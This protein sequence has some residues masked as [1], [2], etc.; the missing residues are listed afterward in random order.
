MGIPLFWTEPRVNNFRAVL[1]CFLFFSPL[2]MWGQRDLLNETISLQV[3]QQR[4][5]ETLSR[6]AEA[7]HF[8]FSYNANL[9]PG[10]SLVSLKV[11]DQTVRSTLN[12]L[13]GERFTYKVVGEH[14]ILKRKKEEDGFGKVEVQ[15]SG[16]L[17][18]SR[19]GDKVP[20]ASIYE[21]NRKTS[22][23]SNREGYYQI[24]VKGPAILNISKTGFQDTVLVLRPRTDQKLTVG[25]MPD[26]TRIEPVSYQSVGGMMA[27][28]PMEE[29]PMVRFWV[30]EKQRELARNFPIPLE[31]IPVQFSLIPS[32]STN[33]LIGSAITHNFS[34]NVLAG[35]TNGVKGVEIGGLF[36]LNR[37][38]V[39]G[40]QIAGLGNL[41][42]GRNRGLQIG[43]LF[44]HNRASVGGMQLGGLANVAR[45]SMNG[46]QMAGLSNVQFGVMRGMQFAGFNNVTLENVDG[47]QLAGFSNFAQ[48][49]VTG[50]QIAGGIN[51]GREIGGAQVG[52]IA[53]IASGSV[54]GA[55]VAGIGNYSDKVNASQV[56][57]IANIS[58]DSVKGAQVA[59][60]FNYGQ[61]VSG[62]QVGLFNY[63][64]SVGGAAVGFFSYARKGY[65][66]VEIGS[67][68]Y[69]PVTLAYKSGG[70]HKFY[71]I[72]ALG[73]NFGPGW[74]HWGVGYG[75]GTAFPGKGRV[76]GN[77]DWLT[78]QVNEG[79][80]W[81]PAVNL[82]SSLSPGVNVRIHPRLELFAGP[83]LNLHISTLKDEAGQYASDL[84]FWEVHRW[85]GP[86]VL[87]RLGVGYQA[88]IRF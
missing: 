14:L 3:Q 53:N 48:K 54:N 80:A 26:P 44:N 16:Y 29:L 43:G 27:P 38:E 30:P 21:S 68:E 1:L 55:Q 85:E 19:S 86:Q 34:L 58:R 13:L 24:R 9:I 87:S 52:G 40:V 57:G 33:G 51:Y 22:A 20:Y 17:V 56:A 11:K 78:W 18:N 61:I 32:I 88:G 72:I 25:L 70:T 5:D 6:I 15:L 50:S 63:A 23:Y 10:D 62:A 74:G 41:N 84:A 49:D 64:D 47:L 45:D 35:Y 83:S 36:N 46:F 8:H 39:V 66:R 65:H 79:E 31:K 59:T 75:A 77:V 69:L 67:R 42:G 4:L 7:G 73:R 71:N 60:I 28:K 82:V 2:L 81:T 37:G 12:E 76:G